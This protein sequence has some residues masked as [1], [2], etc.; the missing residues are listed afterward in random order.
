V[1]ITAP[2]EEALLELDT[3]SPDEIDW[4]KINAKITLRHAIFV[5]KW[6]DDSLEDWANEDMFLKLSSKDRHLLN[7]INEV[8]VDDPKLLSKVANFIKNELFNE[9]EENGN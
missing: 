8:L 4:E 7:R 3:K 6:V 2:L 1:D 9:E 5:Q